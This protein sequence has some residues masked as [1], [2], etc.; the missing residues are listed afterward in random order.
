MRLL[1]CPVSV[2]GFEAA[3]EIAAAIDRLDKFFNPSPSAS[4]THTHIYTNDFWPLDAAKEK[5]DPLFGSYS[6]PI[7]YQGFKSDDGVNGSNWTDESTALPVSDDGQA[8]NSFFGMQYAV[9]FTLTPDYIG[10]LEYT[11]FGDDDMWVFLDNQ[12]VCDIGGRPF[13]GRRI[14]RSVG[15]SESGRPDRDREAHA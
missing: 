12:L 1:L 2:Q 8:H 10:P 15:L 14:R 11:F 13:L 3:D 9:E 7:Y 6:N 4:T 5:K